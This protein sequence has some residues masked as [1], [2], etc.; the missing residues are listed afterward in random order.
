MKQAVCTS[1]FK[2]MSE[3]ISL[4]SLRESRAEDWKVYKTTYPQCRSYYLLLRRLSKSIILRSYS[5]P[6][7]GQAWKCKKRRRLRILHIHPGK[8]LITRHIVGVIERPTWWIFIHFLLLIYCTPMVIS[9]TRWLFIMLKKNKKQHTYAWVYHCAWAA[10]RC[11][12]SSSISSTLEPLSAK[13]K[14]AYCCWYMEKHIK[15]F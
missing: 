6:S 13:H 3:H 14:S 9:T 10:R 8:R 5:A 7:N 15:T 11:G 2:Q 12:S 1:H 4:D